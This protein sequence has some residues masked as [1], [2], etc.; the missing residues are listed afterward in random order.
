MDTALIILES[1]CV[2]F[3]SMSGAIVAIEKKM[4]LFGVAI[5]GLTTSIGGGIIRDLILDITPPM[6]LRN[7]RIAIIAIVTSLIFFIPYIRRKIQEEEKIYNILMFITDSIGLGLFT[8]I[9]VQTAIN[10]G[11]NDNYFLQV[12]VGVIS[13]VGGGVLRDV[14]AGNRPYIFIK[15]F[16][17]NAAL[18]GAIVCVI[19]WNIVGSL[20]AMLISASIIFILRVLAAHYHWSLPKA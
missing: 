1:I 20:A 5:M 7:P 6:S 9:G 12:F 13:G 8:V 10:S 11:F 14:L 19:L 18:I 2:M 4:D 15:H 17:A 3:F 16:Y